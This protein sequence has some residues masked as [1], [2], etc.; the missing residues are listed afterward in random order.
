M[1]LR[2]AR[3]VLGSETDAE[4]VY[5][6]TFLLLA[7][8]AGSIRKRE[9]VASWLHGVAHRLALSARGK[10]ARRQR[11]ER[12]AAETRSSEAPPDSAWS[13]LE[14]TLHDVL[15][16]LPGRYRTPLIYCYLE[17]W[18]QEEVAQ[19]LGKPLGTVRSWLARGR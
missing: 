7:R 9:S 15:A 10:R 11:H 6:A 8:R 12:R 17:G 18:T 4:D 19:Q 3:R 16:Q 1:V 5:Q 13:E 14:E 2:V